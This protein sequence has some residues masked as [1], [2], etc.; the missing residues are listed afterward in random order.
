MKHTQ[1]RLQSRPLIILLFIAAL[2][3][4]N[5]P[6][7]S[8]AADHSDIATIAY[9]FLIWIVIIFCLF[10]YCRKERDRSTPNNRKEDPA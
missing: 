3:L 7:L 6:L 9:L 2:F 10:S 4:L 5:W 1:P 8:I